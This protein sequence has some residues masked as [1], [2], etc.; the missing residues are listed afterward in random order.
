MKGDEIMLTSGASGRVTA[1]FSIQVLKS[2][3]M[4]VNAFILLLFYPFRGRKNEKVV[5]VPSGIVTWKSSA[6]AGGNAG[7]T[8]VVDH[9]VALRRTLA[10][11][12][13]TDGGEFSRRQYLLFVTPRGETMFTQSWTSKKVKT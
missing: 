5:R 8:Q 4:L 13:V 3:L 12:E 2:F 1:L 6:N 11:R 9:E 10:I 7:V